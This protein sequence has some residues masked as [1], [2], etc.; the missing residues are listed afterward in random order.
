MEET[1]QP[2]GSLLREL[3]RRKVTRT[4]LLYILLC[5]GGLQVGEIVLPALGIDGDYG[6]RILLAVAIIAFPVVIAFAWYFQFTSKGIV[7]TTNFVERRVLSNI[8]PINDQRQHK[9]STYFRKE[10]ESRSYNWIISAETGPLS[11]LSFGVEGPVVLGRSL[12]C[13]LAIV[14]P[15]VSRHHARLD[16]EDEQ[17]F[18]ED[19]G[20][21]NGTVVNGKPI[22]GRQPLRHEDEVR[23][24]DIVFRVTESYSR[25]RQEMEA[26]NQ[27]TFIEIPGNKP[28]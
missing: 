18:V 17:L 26:M 19:L 2:G 8:L 22:E 7:R 21:S 15:H 6:N 12:D 1:G 13:D 28:D 9:V 4:C 24:H 23:F 20:S 27:T 14:S 5:W 10:E 25:P 16:L 3:K 11:G